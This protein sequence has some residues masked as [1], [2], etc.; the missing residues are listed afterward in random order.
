MSLAG[1]LPAGCTV[2]GTGT[3][4]T[5]IGDQSAGVTALPPPVTTLNVNSLTT[6]ITPASGTNGI[7]FT[8]APTPV[9]Y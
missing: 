4:E 7:T 5:C 6:A 1:P 8:S 9:G 3:I 2:D